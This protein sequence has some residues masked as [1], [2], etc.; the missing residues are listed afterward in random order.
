MEQIISLLPIN[1]PVRI[2]EEAKIEFIELL[3][4]WDYSID[5]I[6][7]HELATEWKDNPQGKR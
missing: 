7:I 6:E 4:S 2:R 1:H 3:V 5:M